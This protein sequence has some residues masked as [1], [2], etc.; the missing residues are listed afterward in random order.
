VAG[1]L[2]A[3]LLLARVGAAQTAGGPVNRL[4]STRAA[5]TEAA[6]RAESANRKADAAAI[7]TRLATGDFR[8]GDRLVLLVYNSAEEAVRPVPALGAPVVAR[9]LG[10][11]LLVLPG[12]TVIFSRYPTLPALSLVGVLRSELTERVKQHLGLRYAD[13][14]KIV[15][16]ANSLIS[17]TIIGAIGR[18]SVYAVAPESRFSDLIPLAGGFSAD[19]NPD[20][21]T[22]RRGTST[23]LSNGEVR[24][25]LTNGTSIDNLF[26]R[27]GDE[28]VVGKKMPRNWL[29]YIQFSVSMITLAVSLTR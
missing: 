19:A 2:A 20:K 25:A 24:A 7:R 15:V 23:F 28:V 3:T 10:D 4:L 18:G 27:D 6:N 11:T 22:V 29:S 12:Y 8:V 13:T 5:L 1:A 21:V 17:V 14:S 9:N 16:Q 26:M